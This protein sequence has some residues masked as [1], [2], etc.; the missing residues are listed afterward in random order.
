MNIKE[1]KLSSIEKFTASI[2]DGVGVYKN[3]DEIGVTEFMVVMPKNNA[4]W[5]FTES[6]FN[7]VIEAFSVKDELEYTPKAEETKQN[8]VSEDFALKMMAI[9]INKEKFN[10]LK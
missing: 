7:E 5:H 6:M 10:D 8:I 4:V 9:A 3:T 1:T 2:Y